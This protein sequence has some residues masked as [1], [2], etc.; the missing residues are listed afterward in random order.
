MLKVYEIIMNKKILILIIFSISSIHTNNAMELQPKKRK[1]ASSQPNSTSHKKNHIR[2]SL[3][4]TL[5]KEFNILFSLCSTYSCLKDA[6]SVVNN[7][8]QVN[9]S[10]NVLINDDKRTLQLIKQLS[11]SYGYSDIGVTRMLCTKAANSRF[12]LQKAFFV[13]WDATQLNNIGSDFQKLKTIG[14][15]LEFTY[16]HHQPTVLIQ[17][18]AKQLNQISVISKVQVGRVIHLLI[19]NG[20]DIN[21]FTPDRRNASMLALMS[22]DQKLMHTFL[23]H[24]DFKVN[25]QDLEQYTPLHCCF[26]HKCISPLVDPQIDPSRAPFIY[27]IVKKLLEKGADPMAMNNKGKTPLM[28]AQETGY[29]PLIDLLEKAAISVTHA[30]TN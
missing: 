21:V 16:Y 19:E 11:K 18:V 2:P 10:L 20:A 15:D 17:A 4:T 6:A 7:L 5:K 24:P 14:F 8:V 27:E 9:T 29:Q 30:S 25:H 23:D 3:D 28:F 12:T 26:Y 13:G 22:T 1:R